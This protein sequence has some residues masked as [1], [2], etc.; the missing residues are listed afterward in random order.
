MKI[1]EVS[2]RVGLSV[3]TIRY[4]TDQD[5]VPDVTRDNE[6]QRVFN[7]EA[8]TWLLGIKF[9]RDLGIP[10]SEIKKYIQLSKETG[11]AALKKRHIMLLRQRE[12]AKQDVLHSVSRLD[13]IDEKIKQ[14][15]AIMAGKKRD[16]LSA[17][18]RFTT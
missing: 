12:K 18:R 10:I 17:A 4:Y 2:K 5:M 15:Q 8:I 16:S 6:G 13:A 1:S 9:Q 14:E 3:P 11:P 7:D